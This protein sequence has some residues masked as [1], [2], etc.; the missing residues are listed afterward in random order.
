MLFVLCGCRDRTPSG[1]TIGNES[2]KSFA[3]YLSSCVIISPYAT[4]FIADQPFSPCSYISIN[5]FH[6]CAITIVVDPMLVFWEGDT[7][8][9]AQLIKHFCLLLPNRSTT[10]PQQRLCS[11]RVHCGQTQVLLE[12]YTICRSDCNSC[13]TSMISI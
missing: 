2:A 7:H 5:A 8:G 1:V 4:Q 13:V 10:W 11:A 12:V 6:V 9:Q 3:Q